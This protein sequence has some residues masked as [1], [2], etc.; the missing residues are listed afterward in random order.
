MAEPHAFVGRTADLAQL[1]R[2]VSQAVDGHGRLALIAGEP[3]IGKTRLADVLAGW[4]TDRGVCALWGRCR[5]G[6]SAPAFWPWIEVL[7]GYATSRD[8]VVTGP[9][10][11]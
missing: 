2:A 10:A 5:D 4:S 1:R 8:P 9:L 6:D 11:Q 3:G 7:R